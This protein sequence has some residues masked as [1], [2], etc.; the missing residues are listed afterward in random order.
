MKTK[1]IKYNKPNICG[2]DG[3]RLIP[4]VNRITV[5]QWEQVKILQPLKV[6]SGDI[7][8]VSPVIEPSIEKEDAKKGRGRSKKASKKDDSKNE[9]AQFSEKSAIALIDET[10]DSSL[11]KEW[12]SFEKREAVRKAIAAQLSKLE[13]PPLKEGA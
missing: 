1:L 5:E 11:L 9:L 10:V 2:F 4:G 7:E 12:D 13:M 8:D 6:S 3:F